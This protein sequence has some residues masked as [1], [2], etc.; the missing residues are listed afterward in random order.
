MR[1]APYQIPSNIHLYREWT[2]EQEP[3]NPESHPDL[4]K[5]FLLSDLEQVFIPRKASIFAEGP[6][7]D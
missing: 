4:P 7:E 2:E 5:H 3:L 1:P 6:N